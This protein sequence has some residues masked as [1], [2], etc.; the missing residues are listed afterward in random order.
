[1]HMHVVNTTALLFISIA[2]SMR[3]YSSFV[4][5]AT[6]Q[7]KKLLKIVGGRSTQITQFPFA[8]N[9]HLHSLSSCGGTII[10]DRWV[11]TAAHCLVN[12]IASA[13]KKTNIY[14]ETS[15]LT[16]NLGHTTNTTNTPINPKRIIAHPSYK[17][18]GTLFDGGLIELPQRLVFSNDVQPVKLAKPIDAFDADQVFTVVGWGRNEEN[19][20]SSFL[21]RVN[22]PIIDEDICRKAHSAYAQN[23]E[24]LLCAGNVI[25]QDTCRGDSGGPLLLE[26][27]NADNLTGETAAQSWLQV[28]VTSFGANALGLDA[29]MCGAKGSVGY[30]SRSAFLAPWIS[31]VT[32]IPEDQFTAPLPATSIS[33]KKTDT[34]YDSSSTKQKSQATSFTLPNTTA[35]LFRYLATIGSLALIYIQVQ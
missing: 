31:N 1:M 10:S 5:A 26:T 29:S 35:K 11:L 28:G 4:H 13:K 27:T 14:Y 3:Y 17:Y 8:A 16:L 15:T 12:P 32:G 25:G 23:R 9:I 22:I 21:Q 34:N 19:Q 7:P 24:Q 2:L 30:Y 20:K 6:E 33:N 18:N